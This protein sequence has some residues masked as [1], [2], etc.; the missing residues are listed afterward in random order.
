VLIFTDEASFRQDPTLHQTW[1]RRGQQPLV[2][3]T[4]QR[5]TQ[6]IFGAVELFDARCFFHQ[7]KVFN[8]LTYVGF[9]DRLT[10]AY[11]DQPINLIHD[12]AAYHKAPEV[13]AWLGQHGTHMRLHALPPYSP[14]LNAVER[15]WHHVRLTSTHNRYFATE[16]ELR[17]TLH[18]AF[19]DIQRHPEL[20]TGYL[21][22]F[23]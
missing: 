8:A 23:S 1:A 10:R 9:L 15:L 4:G 14:E 17:Q 16:M 2:L 5:H 7:D 12:N 3:T 6:K 18:D 19:R 20:I 22:P 11:P 21:R 13:R